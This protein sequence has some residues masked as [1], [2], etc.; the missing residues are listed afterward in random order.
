MPSSPHNPNPISGSVRAY[1]ES[2]LP[3]SQV[4]AASLNADYD[5]LLL[6]RTTHVMA[7]FAFSN[8]DMRRSYDAL[9]GGFKHYYAEQKGR[10]DTLDLTFIFCVRPEAPDLDT[11]CSNIETD[12]YF[13]RKFVLPVKP[14]IAASL[15]RLPF[16]P[17]SPIEEQTLRPPSAQT[18]LQQCGVPALLAKYLVVQGERGPDRIL[19]D[20]TSGAFGEP[21]ELRPA[22]NSD[23]ANTGQP[24]SR[25]RL[26]SVSIRDFRA[27]RKE[28]TFVLGEDVTVLYG[29]NGFGKTSFFDAIDFA[30]TGEIGRMK[31]SGDAFK[32]AATHLDGKA[33]QSAVSLSFTCNGAARKVTRRVSD[34]KHPLLD[35][36]ST[37]RKTILLEL[38]GGD[39][40]STDRVENFI[41]LFRATHLFSQEH[42]EL[43]KEF[44]DDCCL[45]EEI[46]SR[47]LAFEDYA[48]AIRKASKVCEAVRAVITNADKEM[49]EL[50]EEIAD[51]KR[52]LDRLSQETQEHANI[53]S[54]DA[55][56]AALRRNVDGLGIA[57]P[58]DK[59]EA[60]DVRGWRAAL[61]ARHAESQ[62]R[63]A[64]LSDLAKESANLPTISTD[65]AHMRTQLA[66]KEQALNAS[67][68]QCRA[69][70]IECDRADQRQREVVGKRSEAQSRAAVLQWARVTK[71]DY[72][73]RLARQ[74]EIAAELIPAKADLEEHRASESRAVGAVH[75]QESAAT[76]I[77]ETLTSKRAELSKLEALG[78][79]C[80]AWQASQNRLDSIGKEAQALLQSQEKLRV[81]ELELTSQ[82]AK[83][84]EDKSRLT[85]QIAQVDRSQSELRQLLSQLQAHIHTGE[86]PLC[87]TDH[88]SKESLIQRVQNNLMIDA[89]SG[90]R[91]ELASNQEKGRELAELLANNKEKQAQSDARLAEFANERENLTDQIAKF[92]QDATELEIAI[93]SGGPTPAEQI[94]AREK[95]VRD[96]IETL[97]RTGQELQQRIAEARSVLGNL[98]RA[99][100]ARLANVAERE[101]E[102]S[103]LKEETNQLL[104]D[105]RALQVSLDVELAEL[106]ELERVNLQDLAKLSEDALK[107]ET[108]ATQLKLQLSSLRQEES[109]LKT[110]TQN[111]RTELANLQRKLTQITSRLTESQLPPDI[112]Q[113][114]LLTLIGEEARTQAK[115]LE[116]K[117]TASSIELA[118][119][120]A[121]TAAALTRLRQNIRN[122]ERTVATATANRSR[123]EPWLKYFERLSRLL[124]S[125][126]SD[127]IGHF[128]R[129]YGPRTSVIQRRLRSVYGF[130][131]IEIQSQ[132]STIRVRVKRHG[133]E[134]RP[135]D[136][137]SQSQ[138]QTLLLSLFLTACLS[139]N[140]SSFAP[141]FL[142][143][144]VT[145]FDDLNT[146]AFLDLIIGL[147]E[148]ESSPRQFVIS[149]CDEKFLQLARQKFRHL[150]RRARY[151]RFS[152][153]GEGGPTVEE[154][155]LPME[156]TGTGPGVDER[157][158]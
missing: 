141:V 23:V 58:S 28:Q 36:R 51:E 156:K 41:S 8:G 39:A 56:I 115:L 21:R 42:Q 9:Y 81:D 139:Q 154:I 105:P 53:E 75:A 60:R 111:I 116:L 29:P 66:E 26:E 20:C 59:P 47:M 37:D 63:S 16:I 93:G 76:D 79:R 64:R 153:I 103:R 34:P 89:A 65:I 77:A 110:Q 5:P 124:S 129:E 49:R 71:P 121:T 147:V 140:W 98:S 85:H 84:A 142:D 50:S 150:R 22:L 128:T 55:D 143:D 95:R 149:T 107:A 152:A 125:Q 80:G 32:K 97:N 99:V 118:I 62:R 70:Q 25:V 12:V 94:R 17:L 158:A 136:Y 40:P 43:A 148:S 102:L 30:A 46:V 35:G 7:A 86:C 57:V 45:S 114:A 48:N 104:G 87:G 106:L 138:Q 130:D 73:Q 122:K 19:E 44:Q 3:D 126:Q 68:E 2:V 33:D 67:E 83:L 54:L 74:H 90:A 91:V 82:V 24:V 117:E 92:V 151:Y 10:W 18:F 88:H 119:D 52:E 15:A 137:F 101:A 69:I 144:P 31:L 78:E 120:A 61:E 72:T 13:C 100:A 113:E 14:P 11:F 133:E 38:T 145:H 96:E 4:T 109:S 131:E 157:H 112:G 135:T 123:H 134:L 1:L 6:L 127:A 132:E 155:G 27:Y 108:E 146:Y